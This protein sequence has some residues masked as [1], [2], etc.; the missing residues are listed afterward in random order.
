MKTAYALGTMKD[1]RAAGLLVKGLVDSDDGVAGMAAS[2]LD[3]RGGA[4]H[5]EAIA[6]MLGHDRPAVRRNAAWLL[7]RI[8]DKSMRPAIEAAHRIEKNKDAKYAME[9]ALVKLR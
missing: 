5:K 3:V 1:P 2:A 6:K 7:G 8:G 4:G 9:D